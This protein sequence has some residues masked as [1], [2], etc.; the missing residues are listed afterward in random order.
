[1]Y[2]ALS[3]SVLYLFSSRV[4]ES[5]RFLLACLAVL[6][7]TSPVVGHELAVYTVM[8]NSEDAHPADI[9][10]GSLKEG[11]TVWFWMKDSTENAS[12][13]VELEHDGAAMRSSDLQF[14]CEMDENDTVLVDENCKTRFDYTFNQQNSAGLWNITFMKY[15]NSTLTETIGGSVTIE[16]DVHDEMPLDVVDDAS[17][18]TDFTNKE[19]IAGVTIV[20]SLIGFITIAFRMKDDCSV[21]EE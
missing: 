20:I 21:E 4:A 3:S 18:N 11:D 6:M 9:P 5:M 17:S 8:V 12:L 10:N 15:V 13:V 14:E 1:M 16:E 2:R 19:I 7:L